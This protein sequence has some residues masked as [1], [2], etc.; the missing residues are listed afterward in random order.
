MR[1][2]LI[3]NLFIKVNGFCSNVMSPGCNWV[4]SGDARAYRRYDGLPVLIKEGE[5]YAWDDGSWRITKDKR[6]TNS[7]YNIH[8]DG[9]YFLCGPGINGNKERI[10]SYTLI[11]LEQ[12]EIFINA[13]YDSIKKYISDSEIDGIIW[14]RNNAD[15]CC[16]RA[17]DMGI[18]RK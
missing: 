10:E 9:I 3:Q 4:S 11:P 5:I 7:F 2:L 17:K 15:M 18:S 8:D 1:I 13:D 12:E 6:Y 14:K 16:V